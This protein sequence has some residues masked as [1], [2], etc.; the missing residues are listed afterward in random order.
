M[1]KVAR[2]SILLMSFS[3]WV[4]G[5]QDVRVAAVNKGDRGDFVLRLDGQQSPGVITAR[6]VCSDY[7]SHAQCLREAYTADLLIKRNGAQTA[8]IERYAVQL[9]ED[10]RP[11]TA[12][13]S[14]S[15]P[16]A[17]RSHNQEACLTYT[18]AA[19]LTN[20]DK[21][22]IGYRKGSPSP[23]KTYT[24]QASNAPPQPTVAT[25]SAPPV[26]PVA[27]AP[28]LASP[29]PAAPVEPPASGMTNSVVAKPALAPL[30]LISTAEQ[31][32][33]PQRNPAGRGQT[34]PA[35][36]PAAPAAAPATPPAKPAAQAAAPAAQ[37]TTPAATAPD[38]PTMSA[39]ND[40]AF[41]WGTVSLK[42]TPP[43]SGPA[44]TSIQFQLDGTDLG[45]SVSGPD[46]TYPWDTTT[47]DNKTH[48]L[49]AIALDASGTK[50]K[51]S[52]TV[53][54][55]VGN[56]KV[57]APVAGTTV[58]G[59]VTLTAVG[60]STV[61][62]GVQFRL[63]DPTDDPKQVVP[64]DASHNINTV[65]L[66]GSSGTFTTQ[67]DSTKVA[68]DT[69][70][71]TAVA[72]DSSGNQA[73][74]AIAKFVVKNAPMISGITTSN[75][76]PGE[77]S[78]TVQWTTDKN[79][80]TQVLYGTTTSYGMQ[81]AISD[82]ASGQLKGSHNVTLTGL[83][84]ATT[85]NFQVVADDGNGNISKSDNQT[86]VTEASPPDEVPQITEGSSQITGTFVNSKPAKAR[87]EVHQGEG[88]AEYQ[89]VTVDNST[90]AFTVTLKAPLSTDEQVL[91][92]GVDSTSRSGVASMY[93]VQPSVL[94]W[95]RVRAYFTFGLI[96]SSNQT[97]SS[98]ASN[99]FNSNGSSPYLAF[100]VDNEWLR[101]G[102]SYRTQRF[103]INTFFSARLT[104]IGTSAAGTTPAPATPAG[105]PAAAPSIT[106]FLANQQAGS[107]Q[108][109]FYAPVTITRWDH[110]GKPF[111]LFLAPLVKGG[112][113]TTGGSSS[114]ANVT[115]LTSSS[116]YKFYGVGARLGLV[117]EHLYARGGVR[118]GSAP[119]PWIQ[120]DFMAGRWG[121]FEDV[122][123][124]TLTDAKTG[125]QTNLCNNYEPD[126]TQAQCFLRERLLRYAFEGTVNIPRT[127]FI[128][129]FSA[130]VAGQRPKMPNA[131]LLNGLPPSPGYNFIVPPDDLRFLFGIRLDTKTILGTFIKSP[132]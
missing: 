44:A 108:A 37:A 79:A 48:T 88:I 93:S 9:N 105:T 109:G 98:G 130:N 18:L 85:Y 34:K 123:P 47:V 16:S 33:A 127:P 29:A 83:T 59:V 103:A 87:V 19:D 1:P 70:R 106:G 42:A 13:A 4:C 65:S 81:T 99:S 12:A 107:V 24:A 43:T 78:A 17:G 90:G 128:I 74:A 84:P 58:S 120:L 11:S 2:Y 52:N 86:L 35:T 6:L 41:V 7:I 66:N 55:T 39:P 125:L 119:D 49:T 46:F 100:D 15:K 53:T 50:S 10:C 89:E 5:Q 72:T 76:L 131:Q 104:Q 61:G 129:G 71:I 63:D 20:G 122:S 118:Q 82:C 22:Q 21:Y 25:A 51:P 101:P 36:A 75:P 96:L 94:D 117:G 68:N 28:V 92:F 110:G 124:M 57:T 132:Q 60:S 115:K 121:N 32:Q 91:L 31:A 111:S 112:F 69:H 113:Y 23:E 102:H 27:V 62:I 67:W 97:S 116:F 114:N 14:S 54:V 77:N 126:P 80:C 40:K 73:V 26:G 64:T 95:G 30:V 38:P 45:K 8:A 56:I 3:C